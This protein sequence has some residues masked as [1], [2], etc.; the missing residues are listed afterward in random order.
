MACSE[1][2]AGEYYAVREWSDGT[3]HSRVCDS[4][5]VPAKPLASARCQTAFAATGTLA[6][7]VRVLGQIINY[8]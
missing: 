4:A 5:A 3:S 6:S 2:G 1:G 8:M 7:L